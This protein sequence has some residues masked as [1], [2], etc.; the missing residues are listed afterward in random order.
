LLLH[1]LLE[2]WNLGK[3]INVYINFIKQE[4]W[5]IVSLYVNI[6]FKK[7]NVFF[8]LIQYLSDSSNYGGLIRRSTLLPLSR[9]L[10]FVQKYPVKTIFELKNDPALGTF[11][12]SARMLDIVRLDPWWYPVCDC[13]KIFEGY[14]GAFYCTTCRA[15]EYTVAP[16]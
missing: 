6:Q 7:F 11:I 16:K 5:F 13:P 9:S 10:D 4:A 12:V 3:G 15:K 8:R 1:G 14:I 2:S